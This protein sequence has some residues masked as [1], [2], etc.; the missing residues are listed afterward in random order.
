MGIVVTQSNKNQTE[1][2]HQMQQT[3]RCTEQISSPSLSV[4]PQRILRH[5]GR[6]DKLRS[7]TPTA[8]AIP[9]I[10]R[11][12]SVIR[13]RASVSTATTTLLMRPSTRHE[14][15]HDARGTITPLPHVVCVDHAARPAVPVATSTA[16]ASCDE[17]HCGAVD[18]RTSHTAHGDADGAGPDALALVR[19][20]T[21]R[22]AVVGTVIV[23]AAILG[24]AVGEA[25]SVERKATK[26]RNGGV[27]VRCQCANGGIGASVEI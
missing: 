10:P 15:G 9:R 6:T 21:Q 2:A 11:P 12:S 8:P 3:Y 5:D 18:G 7:C 20:A 17:E 14:R 16:V 1:L 23:V 24:I 27:D 19:G 25:R 26:E 22:R 13:R 4:P